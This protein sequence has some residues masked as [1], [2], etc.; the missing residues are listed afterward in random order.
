MRSRN[1]TFLA[2][3]IGLSVF[4]SIKRRT[5]GGSTTTAVGRDISLVTTP[6]GTNNGVFPYAQIAQKSNSGA[7]RR[8]LAH[9]RRPDSQSTALRHAVC[10]RIMVKGTP[11]GMYS[12]KDVC[13][14]CSRP[15]PDERMARH[16]AALPNSGVLLNLNKSTDLRLVFP[17][18][19]P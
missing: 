1:G 10:A 18:S 4:A 16:F 12:H 3:D 17:I 14:L 13:P 9:D 2:S 5:R 19:H 15:R 6:P 11:R 8:T 7:D